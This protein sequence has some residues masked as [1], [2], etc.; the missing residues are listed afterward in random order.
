MTT[1][2]R[3]DFDFDLPPHRFI[4]DADGEP[5]PEPDLMRWA[6]WFQSTDRHL[7]L[8][9]LGELGTISTVFLGIDHNFS[10]ARVQPVLWETMVFGGLFDQE[11]E[12]Y[13]SRAAA[14]A[15]HEEIVARC[16]AAGVIN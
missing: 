1:M 11:M 12:R 4:L 5:V 9:E 14:L 16:R 3:T 6:Q 10:S 2:T 8:T 15:G 13:R 7:A